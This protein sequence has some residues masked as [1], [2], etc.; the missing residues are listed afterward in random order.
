MLQRLG[1]L[2][3]LILASLAGLAG[4]ILLA[5]C[6]VVAVDV[7]AHAMRLGFFGWTQDFASYGLL[8]S[9][10]L[11]A[12]WL[13]REQGH[14]A[15][16]NIRRLAAPPVQRWMDGIVCVLAI[17]ACLLLAWGGLALIRDA[18]LRGSID[19]RAVAI[20]RWVLYA[21]IPVSFGLMAL[22]FVRVL[23]GRAS[24]HGRGPEGL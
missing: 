15:I 14:V 18:L 8:Y 1:R 16:D 10:L 4:A 13:L 7:A 19:F 9:T 5:I 21:P 3:A 23:L 17:G 11:A 12:P 24:L 6:L 2:H 22:E 20:P